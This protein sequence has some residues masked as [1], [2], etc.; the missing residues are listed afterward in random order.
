MTKQ[1]KGKNGFNEVQWRG[2]NNTKHRLHKGR[3]R[4][5]FLLSFL[6]GRVTLNK[7]HN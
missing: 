5:K 6:L 2:R 3:Q 1:L 4:S 7:P